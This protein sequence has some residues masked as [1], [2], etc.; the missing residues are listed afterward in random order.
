M[1]S[2]FT[3]RLRLELQADGEN[4]TT[5]GQ[6]A[7]TVFDLID[8]ARAGVLAKLMPASGT[9]TLT[10]N[11]GSADEARQAFIKC[12]G[13]LIG[14]VT[15]VVPTAEM[16][17]MFENATT[18]AFTLTVKTA[19]G[20]GQLITQGKQSILYCDGTD[21]KAGPNLSTLDGTIGTTSIAD[22]AITLAKMTN[23]T[24]GGL[25]IY[26]ASGEPTDIGVGTNGFVLTAKGVGNNAIWSPALPLGSITIYAGAT[27]PT[28]WEFCNGGLKDR[29]L[30]ADLFSVLG[31]TFNVGG[32]LST[33]FRLPDLRGRVVAGP[34]DMGGVGSANRLINSTSINLFRH[35]L[36]GA[37][38]EDVHT[39]TVPEMPRHTPTLIG[40]SNLVSQSGN[41][42][43]IGGGSSGS[44]VTPTVA[45]IGGDVAHNNVQPTMLL[46]FIIKVE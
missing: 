30:Y 29:T 11:S 28:G 6:K 37:G 23:G 19:A 1:P 45:E 27:A 43:N 46:N 26:G 13:A 21:V 41:S 32:E 33:Q 20:L 35:T 2:T 24:Q 17:W 31:T 9:V 18:G 42:L 15:V 44:Y 40:G 16:W 12:T 36:G 22:D 5:W 10:A 38:G 34:D 3:D 8:E 4:D 39:L 25:P 7:N 14:N